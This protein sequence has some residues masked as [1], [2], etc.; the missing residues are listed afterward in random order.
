MR[1]L[2]RPIQCGTTSIRN[3]LDTYDSHTASPTPWM[4]IYASTKSSLATLSD[5]LYMEC[6]PLNVSVTLV[7]AGSVVST[8]LEPKQPAVDLPSDSL[9][10]HYMRSMSARVLHQT[11]GSSAMPVEEFARE[12]ALAGLGHTP[13]RYM[14]LGGQ[15][16]LYQILK[17]VPRTFVLQLF[18]SRV[19]ADP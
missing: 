8:S 13:P 11:Q 16:T 12:V 5:A 6:L 10:R 18:W 9:Y 2:H 7:S 3:E 14:T 19:G 17:W 1:T 15:S 4:G